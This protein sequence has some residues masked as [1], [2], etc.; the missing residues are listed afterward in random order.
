MRSGAEIVGPLHSLRTLPAFALIFIVLFLLHA[1]LLQLPYF[2]DEAGYFI[3]AARDLLLTGDPIP[4]STLSNA[5]P[6]LVMAW[7]ALWWKLGGYAPAVTRTAMLAMAAFALLGVYRL[8]LQVCWKRDVAAAATACVALYPVFFIQSAMAHLDV[9]AAAFTIWALGFF[10]NGRAAAATAMFAL[11]ALA[12]ETAVVTPLVL[13]GWE[14][15]VRWRGWPS[16]PDFSGMEGEYR[17]DFRFLWLLLAVVPLGGWFGYHWMRTGFAFGNPEYLRY[18]VEATLDPLRILLGGVRRL[19]QTVG[20]MNLFVLTAAAALAMRRAPLRDA[21]VPR[22]RISFPV[23]RVLAAVIAAHVALFSVVGGAPLAR[24]MLPVLPLVVILCVS[25]LHRRVQ[26]WRMVVAASSLAFV[27]AWFVH[28]PWP[29]APEDNL[30]WRDYVVLHQRA[31]GFLNGRY[32]RARVLTAWPAT[33]ELSKPYLGYVAAPRRVVPVENF[34]RRHAGAVAE[35][36]RSYDLVLAFST[37]YQPSFNLLNRVPMWE[38]MESRFFGYHRDVTP[39]EAAR[40]FRGK[41]VFSEARQGQWV[42]VVEIE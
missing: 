10:L 6:P 4:Q 12:K 17:R 41:V 26:R 5:H 11:A 31:A 38:E 20:H 35:G 9:T 15:V 2:W 24:Y 40:L 37:K 42:A 3:P 23:Q 7:L 25:T 27:M 21:E 18:N 28:P 19:W 34:S 13:V 1:P 14:F 8:A 16:W 30:A 29:F 32:P 39:D 22:R 33:D 36:Q